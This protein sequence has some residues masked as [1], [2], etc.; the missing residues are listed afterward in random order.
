MPFTDSLFFA[1]F[2]DEAARARIS[3]IAQ[4]LRT[5]RHLTTQAIPADRLHIT[6]H[7]LGAFDGLPADVLQQACDTASAVKLPPVEITLDHLESFSSRRAKRPLVLSGDPSPSLH[8]L[9]QSLKPH[10]H[11]PFKPHVT[12]LYD[13]H[14]V[15]REAVPEPVTWTSHE[16]ALMRSHLGQSR[17]ETLARWM[18]KA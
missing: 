18:L 5:R 16:F 12:L 14:R 17:H 3:E 9:V 10:A 6:L 7:Y 8:T 2:P 1:I 13:A 4:R 11:R 15:A